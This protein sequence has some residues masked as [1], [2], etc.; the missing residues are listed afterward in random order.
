MDTF[1]KYLESMSLCGFNKDSETVFTSVKHSRFG[2]NAMKV[3]RNSTAKYSNHGL[4]T[5]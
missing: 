2:S 5:K 1:G 3:V 4:E